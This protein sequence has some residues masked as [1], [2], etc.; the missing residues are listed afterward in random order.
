MLHVPP[1]HRRRIPR[2]GD[3]VTEGIWWPKRGGTL[4]WILSVLGPR[5]RRLRPAF[6]LCQHIGT[7]R[8]GSTCGGVRVRER[9]GIQGGSVKK[10]SV[11]RIAGIHHCSFAP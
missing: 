1:F 7:F 9:H 5:D 3:V 2:L 10:P 4:G 8:L 6:P 11:L